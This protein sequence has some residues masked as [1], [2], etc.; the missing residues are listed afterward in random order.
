M[1]VAI[2]PQGRASLGS[3]RQGHQAHGHV[4]GGDRGGAGDGGQAE[5]DGNAPGQQGQGLG[6]NL[7]PLQTEL[8][9]PAGGGAG[10]QD[11][12]AAT[13]A[14]A[15]GEIA[16]ALPPAPQQRRQYQ[17]PSHQQGDQEP[18]PG[19]QPQPRMDRDEGDSGHHHEHAEQAA[20]VLHQQALDPLPGSGRA[21]GR[22]QRC[23]GHR[24]GRRLHSGVQGPG[25]GWGQRRGFLRRGDSRLAGP[26]FTGQSLLKSL[27]PEREGE[28]TLAEGGAVPLKAP[29]APLHREGLQNPPGQEQ[30]EGDEQQSLGQG[31]AEGRVAIQLRLTRRSAHPWGLRRRADSGGPAGQRPA[32]GPRRCGP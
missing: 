12:G 20:P 17:E 21:P 19:L 1:A 11:Q 27:A 4:Q 30:Q 25:W 31:A 26:G 16:P 5:V 8:G 28:E 32:F 10:E 2:A 7:H 13:A 15:I 22:P 6:W 24:R 23:Q 18:F 9:Q 29:E 14:Q 3:D